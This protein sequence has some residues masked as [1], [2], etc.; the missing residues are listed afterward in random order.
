MT[1]TWTA[2]ATK[3]QFKLKAQ[4]NW[5]I[6][7]NRFHNYAKTT[8]EAR[9]VED[10]KKLEPLQWPPKDHNQV[11]N[12]RATNNNVQCAHRYRYKYKYIQEHT[13]QKVLKTNDAKDWRF[14][15][16]LLFVHNLCMWN[17]R[18]RSS[19]ERGKQSKEIARFFWW[20]FSF[21]FPTLIIF[22]FIFCFLWRDKHREKPKV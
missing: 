12:N 1:L 9:R 18:K 15:S 5:K 8:N 4:L 6:R 20:E 19:S 11:L 22:Y 3:K 7:P 17:V 2:T 16:P 10:L 21:Y 13:I 14:P